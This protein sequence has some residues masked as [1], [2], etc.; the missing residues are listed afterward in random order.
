MTITR[1]GNAGP[2]ASHV[3]LCL[4]RAKSTNALLNTKSEFELVVGAQ[5]AKPPVR[6]RKR[7]GSQLNAAQHD[8][9]RAPVLHLEQTL[10]ILPEK[11]QPEQKDAVAHIR[12]LETIE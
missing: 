10:A 6:P 12:K 5:H 2:A 7:F 1:Q 11:R 3:H 4:V 9:V 8:A